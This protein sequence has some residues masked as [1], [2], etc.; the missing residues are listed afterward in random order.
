VFLK[1]GRAWKSAPL[2]P[3]AD[4]FTLIPRERCK[5]IMFYDEIIQG[6]LQ[7]PKVKPAEE[8]RKET[9]F[10]MGQVDAFALSRTFP[11]SNL[12][13]L[14]SMVSSHAVLWVEIF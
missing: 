12:T 4:S 11:E 14:Q 5:E 2:H 7:K 3:S 10:H 6:G 1:R 13:F 9:I 8:N